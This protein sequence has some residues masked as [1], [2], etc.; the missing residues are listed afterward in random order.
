M[1]KKKKGRWMILL[2]LICNLTMDQVF[3]IFNN[4]HLYKDT[5]KLKE[6]CHCMNI[7]M[8]QWVPCSVRDC[9]EDSKHFSITKK[10]M[11]LLILLYPYSH[12]RK[13]SVF[14][15]VI[16]L[17]IFTRLQE[18]TSYLASQNWFCR[19]LDAF[20][21]EMILVS[22]CNKLRRDPNHIN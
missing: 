14:T 22:F 12:P 5:I 6:T 20:F 15:L 3:E 16:T 21:L 9:F 18:T 4:L 19:W 10:N 2:E 13:G 8:R 17:F 11:L 7:S 1:K